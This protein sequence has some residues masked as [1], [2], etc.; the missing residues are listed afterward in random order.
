MLI[1]FSKKTNYISAVL[2]LERMQM[3]RPFSRYNYVPAFLDEQ[4]PLG[5]ICVMI[6]AN[7]I[8]KR[9]TPE[10]DRLPLPDVQA[11]LQALENMGYALYRTSE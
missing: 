7:N 1:S 6:E 2:S 5:L 4:N 9:L 3:N 8:R 11:V 10:K